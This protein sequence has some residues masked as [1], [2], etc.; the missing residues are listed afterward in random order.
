MTEQDWLADLIGDTD[1]VEFCN[2]LGMVSQVWDDLIDEGK[3]DGVHQA[4]FAA[5]VEIPANPFYR[6]HFDQLQPLVAQACA[7]YIA[8]VTLEAAS[9]HDR[10]LAFVLRDSLAAVIQQCV[11]I[12]RGWPCALANGPRIRRV[13]SD[14]SLVDYLG[15]LK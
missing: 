1:A 8:S 12:A 3:S 15:G 7:D 5:L 13:C 14:E 11:A 4:M 9:P 2:K 10:T 6:Q